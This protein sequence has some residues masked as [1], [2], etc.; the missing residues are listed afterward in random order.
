MAIIEGRDPFNQN[1]QKFR[2]K[3]Q[4]IG[5]I[6]PEIFRKNWSTFWGGSLFPV[7]PIGIIVLVEWIGHKYLSQIKMLLANGR[8]NPQH[9][10]PNNFESCCV[11]LH[12]AKL[13][14]GFKL[15]AASPNNKQQNTTTCNRVWKRTQHKEITTRD[16]HYYYY[17]KSSLHFVYSVKNVEKK[18]QSVY[19]LNVVLCLCSLFVYISAIFRKTYRKMFFNKSLDKTIIFTC[20][21]RKTMHNCTHTY[22][23]TTI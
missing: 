3:A 17:C 1:F 10:W 20:V 14:T 5:W 16:R 23:P 18:F 15:C 2:S 19:L 22:L 21:I 9:F 11:H 12:L 8:N 4:W 6:Q 13:L 7:G